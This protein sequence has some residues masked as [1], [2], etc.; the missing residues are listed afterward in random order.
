M[1]RKGW[2]HHG[3]DLGGSESLDMGAAMSMSRKEGAIH[4]KKRD[5]RLTSSC[6][7]GVVMLNSI[8]A[9]HQVTSGE[10]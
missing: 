9:V 1:E 2:D 7:A 6:K 5:M 3:G 10:R 4:G 8:A